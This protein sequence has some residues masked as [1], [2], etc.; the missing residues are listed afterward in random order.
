[1]VVEI[2]GSLSNSF[3]E[4][5]SIISRVKPYQFKTIRRS[6]QN[7]ITGERVLLTQADN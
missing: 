3:T 6:G 2:P 4:T 1:M 7:I 5:T